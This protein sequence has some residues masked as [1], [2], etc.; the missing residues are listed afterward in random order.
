MKFVNAFA[1]GAALATICVAGPAFAGR[2]QVKLAGSSTVLPFANIAAEQFGKEGKFK[3]PIVEGGGTGAGIK[4]FCAGVG[5]DKIDIAN[6]S[7]PMKPSEKAECEAAGVK[8]IAEIKFGYDGIVFAS[9]SKG[10]AFALTAKDLYNALAAKVVVDGKLVDNPNQSLKSVNA[11]FPD[12]PVM[13]FVPG[14]KHGTRE[15][16]ET[17]VMIVGCKASGARAALLAAAG[18]DGSSGGDIDKACS[19]FRKDGASVDIDGDYSET[20]ARL[21]S[22]KKSIGIF[23]LSFYESNTD[24]LRVASV[25]G[26]KPSVASVAS[27]QYSV[28]RPLFFYVKKAHIGIVPGLKEFT[29]FFVSSK[30]AGAKG[31]LV[32]A[33]LVPM[34][35]GA[36]SASQNTAKSMAATN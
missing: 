20:L 12:W 15:V 30:V 36:L 7:R 11:S 26:V 27:G 19:K 13:F 18:T 8:D 28:S 34:P 2:D 32:K 31:P 10:P 22:N 16:F 5:E 14:E 6:A 3:T 21:A 4:Q 17:K 9:D 29:E 33:G 25:E 24:K 23:G 35:A 1:M